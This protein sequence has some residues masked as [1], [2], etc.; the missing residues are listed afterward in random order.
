MSIYLI[1]RDQ[2]ELVRP[3]LEDFRRKTRPRRHDLYDIL[4]AILYREH[5][6]LKWRA[7]PAE[8]PPWR[9]VH[10]YSHQWSMPPRAGGAPPMETVRATLAPYLKEKT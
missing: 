4:C 9:T 7:L 6:H 3:L 2:F 5:H 10:E 1:T 8:F